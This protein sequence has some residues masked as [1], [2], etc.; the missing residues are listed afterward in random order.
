MT[1]WK[2]HIMNHLVQEEVKY[3]SNQWLHIIKHPHFRLNTSLIL[4]NTLEKISSG[5][6]HIETRK[7]KRIK[8]IHSKCGFLDAELLFMLP[9]NWLEYLKYEEF[10]VEITENLYNANCTQIFFVEKNFESWDPKIYDPRS[11]LQ[12]FCG[13]SHWWRRVRTTRRSEERRV[14][15]TLAC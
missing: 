11:Y 9:K 8:Q 14:V 13:R 10:D 6:L 7:L 1:C 2:H 3:Y 4:K 5:T 12:I 15:L